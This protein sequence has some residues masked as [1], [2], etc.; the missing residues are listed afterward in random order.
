[1][2]HATTTHEFSRYAEVRAAL[3]DPALVPPSPAPDAGPPGASVAWLRA[4]VA[5]FASG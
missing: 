3:A 1:M 4:T 2:T 5:R